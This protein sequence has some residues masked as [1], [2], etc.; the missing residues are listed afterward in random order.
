MGKNWQTYKHQRLWRKA[1]LPNQCLRLLLQQRQRKVD[2]LQCQCLHKGHR[3]HLLMYHHKCQ[4]SLSPTVL[5]QDQV[6]ILQ[7]LSS[8]SQLTSVSK[9]LA[10]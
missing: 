4:I 6:L 3:Q 5:M 1:K 2:S 9:K 8:Q 10:H 7:R